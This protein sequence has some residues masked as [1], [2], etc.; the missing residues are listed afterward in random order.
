MGALPW[1]EYGLPIVAGEGR[2]PRMLT[3]RTF[4]SFFGCARREP[5]QQRRNRPLES[6]P[7]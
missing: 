6:C 7:A 5:L 4:A 3:V 2:V 1:R